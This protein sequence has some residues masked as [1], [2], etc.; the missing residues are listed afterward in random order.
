[1]L[2]EVLED[3]FATQHELFPNHILS[4]QMI[5]ERYQPFRTYTKSSDLRAL[6]VGVSPNDVDVVN[7]WQAVK[8][9]K[10]TRL[11]QSMR[12]YYAA[13]PLFKPSFLRYTITM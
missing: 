11:G 9:A 7:R 13:I 6:A 4:G 10:G 12:Q 5:R 8:R 1:M 3:L 2:Q